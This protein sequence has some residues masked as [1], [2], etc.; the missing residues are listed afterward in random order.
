MKPIDVGSLVLR[1]AL[2]LGMFFGHGLGKLTGFAE[3]SGRFPDPLGL[4]S[5][6][7]LV[8]MIIAEVLIFFDYASILSYVLLGIGFTGMGLGILIGFFSMVNEDED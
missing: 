3:R 8:L 6:A 5:E 1:L 4:G 2:G 7:S